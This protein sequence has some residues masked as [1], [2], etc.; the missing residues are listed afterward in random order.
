MLT[1]HFLYSQPCLTK[2]IRYGIRH[3]VLQ[4]LMESIEI[5]RA[6]FSHKWKLYKSNVIARVKDAFKG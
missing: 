6:I 3:Q 1:N 2:T 4:P 5:F